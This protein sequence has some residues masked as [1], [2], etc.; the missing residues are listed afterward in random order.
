MELNMKTKIRMIDQIYQI[1]REEGIIQLARQSLLFAT[2]N[3]ISKR[4]FPIT[5]PT[6]VMIRKSIQEITVRRLLQRGFGRRL[7]DIDLTEYKTS[8]T[9]FILGSGSSIN[10][11]SESG[12]AHI[13]KNDSFGLNYWPIHSHVPTLHFFELPVDHDCPQTTKKYY[14]L[15]RHRAGEYSEVP[16]I[17][18]DIARTYNHITPEEFPEELREQVF[19]AKEI[20]IPWVDTDYEVFRRSL[21]WFESNGYF[22][23]TG[24]IRIG[25]KKRA[26]ISF[27]IFVAIK[28]GYENI[29]LCGVDMNDSKYFYNERRDDY[30]KRGIPLPPL[31]NKE[32][33]KP[34]RTNDP[35]IYRPIFENVLYEIDSSLLE[36]RSVRLFTASKN[37]ATYPRLPYYEVDRDQK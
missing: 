31:P 8:N 7:S 5:M 19:L 16:I 24:H 6:Y 27:L 15:L 29:V 34:H 9:L 26:S 17:I 2:K 28:L 23:K 11:I 14:E 20:R 36:P 30:K 22:S 10:E 12:W 32:T 4:T 25:L 13:E 21:K 3:M 18:K 35:D 33:E 1:Y 37:S